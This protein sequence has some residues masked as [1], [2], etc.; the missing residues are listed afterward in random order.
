[1]GGYLQHTLY[2]ISVLG[3][4]EETTKPLI[5][6]IYQ[7]IVNAH[8]HLQ[9]GNITLSTGELLDTNINRSPQSYLLNPEHERDQYKYDVD[10]QMTVLKFQSRTGDDLGLVSWFAVHGVSVNNT[11]RLINGDNKGYAAYFVEKFMN[12]ALPGK[13]PFVAAFAQSNEGD[14]SPNVLGSFCTGTDIP[15]DGTAQ[16]K[17]PTG[18]RCNGRGPKWTVSD[19]ESNRVIGTNQALKSLELYHSDW[20]FQVDGKVDFVQKYWDITKTVIPAG[21]TD[22]PAL[23]GFYQNTTSGRFIWNMI[24]NAIKRPTHKQ[25]MCQAPKPIL[26]DTGE[27][28]FLPPWQPRIIDIQLFRV[29][30]IFIYAVPA[31][32]TTMSGRRLQR[33]I[34]AA[35]IKHGLGDDRSTIIHS[36]PANGYASYVTTFEEY[37]HQRYEGASTPYGPHTLDGY[38]QVFEELV[39][40]MANP[41]LQLESENLPDYTNRTFDFSPPFRSDQPAMFKRF[42]QTLKDVKPTYSLKKDTIV[43]ALFVAGNPRNDPMLGKTFL[44]VERKVNESEWQVILT[45]SDYNTRFYWR[46]Q[47]Q[48]FGM[49]EAQIEW[50]IDE[51]VEKGTYRI[52]YFGNHKAVFSR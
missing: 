9:E 22:G 51:D 49:S 14:V 37:Q 24:R 10:K 20:Q 34:K 16:T 5:D 21:T 15:C 45:D 39:E 42:G 35:L 52:G 43:M 29:G 2:E 25:A 47:N 3:W 46:Y 36:G 1:M 27:I 28:K 32:F 30:N 33:A 11:N 19:L 12:D 44:T 4:I 6:G 41:N 18:S 40:K 8:N 31:E 23:E 7:S 13:G 48:L 26:L 50:H 38:I 17:C